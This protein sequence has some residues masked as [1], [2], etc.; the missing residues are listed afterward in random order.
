VAV[1]RAHGVRILL[2]SQPAGVHVLAGA[3]AEPLLGVVEDVARERALPRAVV[4]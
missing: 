2:A 1:A 4:P 3:L